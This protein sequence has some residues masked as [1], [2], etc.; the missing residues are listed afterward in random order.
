MRYLE[1]LKEAKMTAL[2]LLSLII[3]WLIAGI[4]FSS[5]EMSIYGIPIWAL[6]G[7]LGVWTIAIIIAITLSRNIQ[8]VDL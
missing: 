2:G 5:V 4:A 1:I 3:F 8:D 6:V 7:T